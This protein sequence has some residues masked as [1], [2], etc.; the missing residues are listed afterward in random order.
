MENNSF[1]T[2]PVN[3]KAF[4]IVMLVGGVIALA[5]ISSFLYA[6][7]EAD[8]VDPAWSK[9]WM[10]RPLIIVPLAGAAGGGFLYFMYSRFQRGWAKVLATLFGLLGFLVAVWLGTVLGLVGTYWH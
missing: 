5:L 7:I 2:R 6:A 10:A 4:F 9:F 1:L 8:T 3:P